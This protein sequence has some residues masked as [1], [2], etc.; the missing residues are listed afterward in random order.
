MTDDEALA[1]L[2]ELLRKQEQWEAQ[3]TPIGNDRQ[4]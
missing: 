3:E 4:G 1:I 2:A